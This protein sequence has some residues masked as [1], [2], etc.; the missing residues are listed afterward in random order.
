VHQGTRL[1]TCHL[2][3]FLEPL[4]Y[5]SPDCLVRQRSNGY[6]TPMVICKNNK[7][8]TLR[9]CA[10]RSQDRHQK[11][12]RTVNSDCPVHHQTI[13]WPSCQKLQRSEPNGRVTWLA[14]RTVSGGAPDC[15]VCHAIAA[16]TNGSFAGWGYKYPQPPTIHGIQVFSLHTSY[17]SYSI[18]YKTQTKDQIISQVQRS[19]QSI[20]D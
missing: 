7:C 10:H 13:R 19:F 8:A 3:E 18:Q 17:K 2:R 16:S 14:H 15:P 20:S 5:N 4:R 1:Q 6:T 12:H 11:A 9:A